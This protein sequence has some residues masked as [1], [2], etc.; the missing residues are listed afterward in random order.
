MWGSLHEEMKG[1]LAAH[2]VP[3]S[4]LSLSPI[5]EFDVGSGKFT[6]ESADQANAFLTRQYR[7]PYVVP[8][9]S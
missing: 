3:V 7:A 9:I 4:E 2:A 5:L 6:G 8:E 1:H